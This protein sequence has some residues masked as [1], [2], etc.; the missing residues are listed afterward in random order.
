MYRI[1]KPPTTPERTEQNEYRE[2]IL[3]ADMTDSS[4]ET[5]STVYK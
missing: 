2:V 3:V 5:E 1:T 4:K